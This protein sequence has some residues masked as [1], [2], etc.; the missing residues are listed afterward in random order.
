MF[1]VI[2][3]VC[4][5]A[6]I[7]FIQCQNPSDNVTLQNN[8]LEVLNDC[9]CVKHYQCDENGFIITNGENLITVK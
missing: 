1:R 8:V 6:L 3:L 9:I 2:S 5:V 4:L 7:N